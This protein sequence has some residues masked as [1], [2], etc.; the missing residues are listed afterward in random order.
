MEVDK[1]VGIAVLH[2]VAGDAVEDYFRRAA[3]STADHRFAAG[4]GFEIHQAKTFGLAG[5]RENFASGVARGELRIGKSAEEMHMRAH[6][7]FLGE[8]FEPVAVIA[9]ANHERAAVRASAAADA[10]ER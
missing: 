1:L 10:A 5:Q 2:E 7:T 6:A 4:H 9:F 8:F 3:V